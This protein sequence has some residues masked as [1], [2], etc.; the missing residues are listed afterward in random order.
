MANGPLNEQQ[1]RGYDENGFVLAKGFFD[2]EEI[3]LLR[4]AAKED[5]ELDQHSF[6]RGDG[7]GG[8][9]RLYTGDGATDLPASAVSEFEAEDFI[10]VPQP[11]IPDVV[12]PVE[13]PAPPPVLPRWSAPEPR[14]R[15]RPVR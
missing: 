6:G 11:A 12:K 3:G 14:H 1:I 5:R 2:T 4:R 15:T 13:P 9:V 10:P 8:T 7:E